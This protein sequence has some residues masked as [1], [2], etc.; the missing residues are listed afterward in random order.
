[1]HALQ[2]E[3]QVQLVVELDLEAVVGVLVVLDQ[4][5]DVAEL[6]GL[7]VEVNLQ[8][9]GFAEGPAPDSLQAEPSEPLSDVLPVVGGL[10]PCLLCL[11]IPLIIPRGIAKGHILLHKPQII[12]IQH[13]QQAE[14]PVPMSDVGAVL[15]LYVFGLL[16][17]EPG[18]GVALG[19]EVLEAELGD[20]VGAVLVALH[21]RVEVEL[22]AADLGDAEVGVE[23][24]VMVGCLD[25]QVGAGVSHW[26]PQL[27]L[28]GGV[29]G[30]AVVV[31]LL[32]EA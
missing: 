9:V 30:F 3:A 7:W 12:D 16:D 32:F 10:S 25:E 22:V 1:V 19:V 23:F 28:V 20:F 13:T 2:H 18:V 15:E 4:G 5:S 26:E 6:L 24:R 8:G 27:Q 11:E 14:P 31:H 21:R 29:E 17:A